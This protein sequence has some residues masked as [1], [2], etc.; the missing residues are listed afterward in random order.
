MKTKPILAIAAILLLFATLATNTMTAGT[1]ATLMDTGDGTSDGTTAG[2]SGCTGT[3][4]TVDDTTLQTF[5]NNRNAVQAAQTLLS[6]TPDPANGNLAFTPI[7]VAGILG[8]WTVE[9]GITFDKLEHKD[10]NLG[11]RLDGTK[12]SNDFARSWARRGAYG[13]GIAQW[14]WCKDAGGDGNRACAL[15]DLAESMGR[16]W[17]DPDVQ[18]RMVVNELAGPYHG[19]Y[20]RLKESTTAGDAARIWLRQYE[21]VDNGTGD[22]RAQAAEN[23]LPAIQSLAAGGATTVSMGDSCDT[24]ASMS[25]MVEGEAPDARE[26][27]RTFAWM[28]SAMGVCKDGDYGQASSLPSAWKAWM[29]QYMNGLGYQCFWYAYMRAAMVHGNTSAWSPYLGAGYPSGIR[30]G[31]QGVSYDTQPRAGDLV[32]NDGTPDELASAGEHI[33]FI[34]Q[35]KADGTLVISEGNYGE[36]AGGWTTYNRRELHSKGDYVHYRYLHYKAWDAAA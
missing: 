11:G 31:Q 3:E 26:A 1:I 16:N 21:G 17:Y 12:Q 36:P 20:E 32:A 29:R 34:E 14:T 15:I 9:S 4:L 13:L 27:G 24:A 6:N 22:V 2:G 30:D 23:L 7:M 28:C 25:G 18:M 10:E 19:V 35:V 5:H 8:N 33:A